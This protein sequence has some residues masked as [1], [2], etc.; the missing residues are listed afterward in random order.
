MN[1]TE[2]KDLIDIVERHLTDLFLESN[3]L[4]F[5]LNKVTDTKRILEIELDNMEN[6][7]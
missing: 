4:E 2:I 1:K 5:K 7:R 3:D 6:E